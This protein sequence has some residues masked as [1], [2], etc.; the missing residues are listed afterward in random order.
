ML[1]DEGFEEVSSG[2]TRSA[3]LAFIYGKKPVS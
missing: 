3:F 1:M 2:L